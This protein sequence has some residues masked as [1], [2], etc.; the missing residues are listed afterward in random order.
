MN[1]QPPFFIVG[2]PRSGTTLLRNLLRSHPNLAVAPESHFVP[3]LYRELGEP[4][5]ERGRQ[6]LIRR[7]LSTHWVR[8]WRIGASAADF[9]GCSTFGEIVMRLYRLAAGEKQ[10]RRQGDKTPAYAREIPTLDLIFPGAQYIHIIRD[11]R[12][13]ALSLFNVWFGHRHVYTAARY[14]RDH[15]IDGRRDGRPL[16]P[17]RYLEIFYEDLLRDTEGTM[18]TVCGFLGEPFDPSV[19]VPAKPQLPAP[20]LQVRRPARMVSSSEVVPANTGKWRTRMSRADVEIFETAAGDLLSELG[21]ERVTGGRRIGPLRRAYWVASEFVHRAIG[22]AS[23][24]RK[25]AWLWSE[26][27]LLWSRLRG[28]LGAPAHERPVARES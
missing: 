13:V 18:R 22:Y 5:D 17:D 11:G 14:W 10:D 15:V 20:R 16:G 1:V 24:G 7:I 6:R 28:R 23:R 27:R 21:Y 19:L 2:S 25:A 4:A 3:I 9:D 12:D 26:V 8:A